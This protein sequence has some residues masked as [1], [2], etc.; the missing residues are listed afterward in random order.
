VIRVPHVMKP[1]LSHGGI[2]MKDDYIEYEVSAEVEK[3]WE[4]LSER[5]RETLCNMSLKQNVD[6]RE[7]ISEQMQ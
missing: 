4:S 3:F 6:L 7:I 5:E 2:S 1:A